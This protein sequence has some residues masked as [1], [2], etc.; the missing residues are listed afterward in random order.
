MRDV[1]L[2]VFGFLEWICRLVFVL[3]VTVATV[4]LAWLAFA[5]FDEAITP[6]L[7]KKL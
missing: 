4:G 6:T 5:D 2:I 7:W 1:V 3:L